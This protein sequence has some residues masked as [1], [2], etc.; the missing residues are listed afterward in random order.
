MRVAMQEKLSTGIPTRSNT[1]QPVQ[2]QKVANSLKF[3]TQ[4]RCCPVPCMELQQRHAVMICTF[5]F[6]YSEKRTS[7]QRSGKGAIR[8]RFPLRKPRW[9]KTNLEICFYDDGVHISDVFI[10]MN[11]VKVMMHI[12]VFCLV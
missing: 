12:S 9:E 8:K 11:L 1:N 10:Q 3:H 5:I 6:A 2:P 7:R 4:L